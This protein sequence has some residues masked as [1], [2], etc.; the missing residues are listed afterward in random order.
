M[1]RRL[2]YIYVSDPV[3][4]ALR[5]VEDEIDQSRQEGRVV[6]EIESRFRITPT[7]EP[8]VAPVRARA[9]QAQ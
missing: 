1:E 7:M 8:I 5:L 4:R 9:L 3:Q 2:P 6:S